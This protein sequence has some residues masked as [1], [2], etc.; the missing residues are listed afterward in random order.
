MAILGKLFHKHERNMGN[1]DWYWLCRDTDTGRVFIRHWSSH[2]AGLESSFKEGQVDPDVAKL[3]QSGQGSLQNGFLELI[4][5]L[6]TDE[7][8]APGH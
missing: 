3:L 4:G 1:E 8:H 2:R 7:Y 5:S 6:A